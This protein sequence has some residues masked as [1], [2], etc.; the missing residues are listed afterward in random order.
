M[1]SNFVTPPDFVDA[2][3]HTITVVDATADQIDMLVHACRHSDQD[4]NVYLYNTAMNDRDWLNRAIDLS[5]AV[6]INVHDNTYR[7]FFDLEKV[8][9]FGPRLLVNPRKLSYPA[10]YFALHIQSNK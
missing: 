8:Y 7:D 4:Y 1:H 5:D 2:K 10:Q 9:N 3:N 6:L